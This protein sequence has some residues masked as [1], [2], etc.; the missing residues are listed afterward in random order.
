MSGPKL[1]NLLYFIGILRI[2]LVTE[3][4][5]QVRAANL[6]D[7]HKIASRQMLSLGCKKETQQLIFMECL[8]FT[9]PWARSLRYRSE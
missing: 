7:N 2:K 3:S 1:G 5:K 4:W 9:K 6:F 8:L